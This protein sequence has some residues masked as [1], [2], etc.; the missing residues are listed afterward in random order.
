L[1]F[2]NISVKQIVYFR[3]KLHDFA[4]MLFHAADILMLFFIAYLYLYR[5]WYLWAT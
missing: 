1:P 3:A 5:S 4:S 2:N